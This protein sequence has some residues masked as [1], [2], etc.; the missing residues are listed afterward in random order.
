MIDRPVRED[1]VEG[2]A[3][4]VFLNMTMFVGMLKIF[5]LNILIHQARR[6]PSLGWAEKLKLQ[7]AIPPFSL[8]EV[9]IHGR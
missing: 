7:E 3:P 5:V 1:Q 2:E 8:I 4:T 6:I 9:S